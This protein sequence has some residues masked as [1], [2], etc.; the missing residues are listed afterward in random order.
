MRREEDLTERCMRVIERNRTAAS[1]ISTPRHGKQQSLPIFIHHS[2]PLTALNLSPRPFQPHFLFGS[3]SE[4]EECIEM[5][6]DLPSLDDGEKDPSEDMRRTTLHRSSNS[7]TSVASPDLKTS[8][9]TDDQQEATKWESTAVT[10]VRSRFGM[11]PTTAYCDHC[12]KDV[13]TRVSVELPGMS[14]WQSWGGAFSCCLE[15]DT[16]RYQDIRH[17]CRRCRRLLAAVTPNH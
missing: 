8:V 1:Q 11:L 14:P 15:T 17:Y 7:K 3:P 13:S 5:I 9:T 4:T 16:A 6:S 12:K 2:S 10:R